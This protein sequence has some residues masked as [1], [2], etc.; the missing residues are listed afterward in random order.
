MTNI[1]R[2]RVEPNENVDLKNYDTQFTGQFTKETAKKRLKQNKKDLAKMQYKFYATNKY[3]MLIVLQAM[4][5]AGKDGAIRHVMSG[6]N[7]QGCS[8]H[9]FKKPSTNELEHDFLWRHF[10]KLPERGQIGIFNRSHYEN[11]LV[12]KVHPEYILSENLPNINFRHYPT[13]N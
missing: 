11:V 4:D 7:P 9:S 13:V 6:I 3:S 2:L 8:V 10:C 12:T 1:S 5:A